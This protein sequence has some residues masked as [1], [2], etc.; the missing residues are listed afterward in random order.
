MAE[1][2]RLGLIGTGRVAGSGHLPAA[3][4][5]PDVE[6]TCLVD[7]VVDRARTLAREFGIAPRIASKTEEILGQ[8]DGAVIATPNHTHRD[9]A[10]ACAKAEVHV[11]IEKPLATTMEDCRAI[12]EAAEANRIVVAVG[13]STRPRDEVVLLHTLLKEGYFG[14]VHRFVYQSGSVG[15]WSPLSAYNLDLKT[16]GGG[17]LVVTGTH[18]LDRMLYW[19]G[20]PDRVEY[21]D[22]A[23]GGPEAHCVA[24]VHYERSG[25]GFEGVIRLSKTVALKAGFVMDTE[26]GLVLLPTRHPAPLLFQPRGHP[27]LRTRL[28]PRGGPLFQQGMGD[29]A[30]QLNNFVAACRGEADPL[31]DGRQ[32]MESVRL[33]HELYACRRPMKEN[34]HTAPVEVTR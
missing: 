19:F 14:A 24:T 13:Y 5:L 2:F 30:L 6:L 11:L 22:D 18:F 3:L 17:V 16:S 1:P 27:G 7:P 34:G 4:S 33:I 20:Y 15:G 12:I 31:V 21:E 8:V 23:Q 28:M 25:R 26:A 10:L 29:F 32:G 9:L